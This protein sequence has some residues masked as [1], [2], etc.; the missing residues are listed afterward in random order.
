MF[1]EEK[2]FLNSNI[3]P[4]KGLYC[5]KILLKYEY[6]CPKNKVDWEGF[7]TVLK[8]ISLTIETISSLYSLT[9]PKYKFPQKIVKHSII[10]TQEKTLNLIPC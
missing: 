5:N 9:Y 8:A 3:L 7:E 1:F 10:Q 6:F 4:R 2:N